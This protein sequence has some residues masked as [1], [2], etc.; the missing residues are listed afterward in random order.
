MVYETE[1][2]RE[3]VPTMV[4]VEGFNRLSSSSFAPLVLMRSVGFS[5]ANAFQ[6]VRVRTTHVKNLLLHTYIS[7]LMIFNTHYTHSL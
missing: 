4:A 1:R 7:N 2:Q 3:N 6:P 5:V